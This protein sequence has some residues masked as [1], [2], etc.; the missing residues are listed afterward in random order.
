MRANTNCSNFS[1]LSLSP[2]FRNISDWNPLKFGKYLIYSFTS[3]FCYEQKK[4]DFERAC[5]VERHSS[6]DRPSTVIVH[7]PVL[8]EQK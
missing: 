2:D 4:S 5:K 3:R 7:Y 6:I 1:P 8:F